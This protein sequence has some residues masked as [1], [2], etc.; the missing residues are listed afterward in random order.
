[1]GKC[2]ER[3]H[4]IC[5]PGYTGVDCAEGLP[6]DPPREVVARLKREQAS[7]DY[8]EAIHLY[9][10]AGEPTA[11]DAALYTGGGE[12]RTCPTLWGKCRKGQAKSPRIFI[13]TLPNPMAGAELFTSKPVFFNFFIHPFKRERAW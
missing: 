6:G 2:N 7:S 3:G 8:F 4:C 11:A 5:P 12:E 9:D 10:A 13:Y 1:M